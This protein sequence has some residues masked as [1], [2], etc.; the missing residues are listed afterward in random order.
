MLVLSSAHF[1]KIL[2][3]ILSMHVWRLT[4]CS[5]EFYT[6][7][8]LFLL[9]WEKSSW[10]SLVEGKITNSDNNVLFFMSCVSTVFVFFVS[11][12]LPNMAKYKC[13]KKTSRWCTRCHQWFSN[14]LVKLL[15]LSGVKR[16]LVIFWHFICWASGH[17]NLIFKWSH[18]FLS[19]CSPFP[20]PKL[21]FWWN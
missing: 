6:H 18:K 17:R 15:M 11:F 12:K 5:S 16:F 1:F 21:S 10:N 20:F 14:A 7:A 19:F 9:I 3:V 4:V 8:V 2:E 13:H